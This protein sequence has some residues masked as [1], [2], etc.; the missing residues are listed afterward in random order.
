MIFGEKGIFSYIKLRKE[1]ANRELVKQELSLK[2]RGKKNIVD[3]ISINSLDIDL[4]DEQA[5]KSLGY[6]NKNEI[7][8]YTKND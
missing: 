3:A 2:I 6:V 5:R 4:L 8:I 7:V 1:I